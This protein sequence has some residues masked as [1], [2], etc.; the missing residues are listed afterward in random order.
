MALA[1]ATNTGDR[2]DWF[3]DKGETGKSIEYLPEMRR[4]LIEAHNLTIGTVGVTILCGERPR[5]KNRHNFRRARG[6]T[7]ASQAAQSEL[8]EAKI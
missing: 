3:P 8:E 2:D 7:A 6:C 4:K 1:G 5:M